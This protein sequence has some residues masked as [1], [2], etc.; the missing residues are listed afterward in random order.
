MISRSDLDRL[1][2]LE[3][4]DGIVSVY[5]GIEPRLRYDWGQHERKFRG[6]VKR[7]LRRNENEFARAAVEREE[8]PIVEF[9]KGIAP[10]GRGLAVF[11]SSPGKVWETF[12]LAVRVPTF[13]DVDVTP[14]AGLL[15]RIV[16]EF[17]RFIV[18]VVQRDRAAVYIAEQ[19]TGEEEAAIKSEVPG[20]HDQ[21]GWAQARFQRHIEVHVAK[22][23]QKVVEELSNLYYKRPFGRL[24][25]GGTEDTVAELVKMLPDPIERRLIGMFP[26]DFKHEGEEAVLERARAQLQ[27][28][29]RRRERELVERVADAA[30]SGGK[31]AIG[32]D[33][34][35]AVV[36]E[37]RVE[38]LLVA[39]GV[40]LEGS[41]CLNC[42]Y[43]VAEPFE[44]CPACGS[45]SEVTSDIVERA[46]ERALLSGAQIETVFGEGREWL[47]ARGGLGAVLRF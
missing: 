41:T 6:A 11:A 22:H 14:N 21:G 25:I 34:T 12:E 46:V 31:G 29:E 7:F 15:T 8:A 13:V 17:P 35:L 30:Q 39:D 16:D 43:F 36:L 18:A 32:V 9:L 45:G 38:T 3:S 33:A 19:G 20:Q 42:D 40:T 4:E 1:A 2:A 28:D 23:L 37:G 24:A 47:L 10:K 26:V 27:D 44:R 5:I